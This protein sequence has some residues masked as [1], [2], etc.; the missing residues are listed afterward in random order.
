MPMAAQIRELSNRIQADLEATS[1]YFEHTKALWRLAKQIAGLGQN[2]EIE[3]PESGRALTLADLAVHSQDYVVWICR[4]P[5]SSTSS[6]SLKISSSSCSGFGLLP[7]P[8]AFPT[9]IGKQLTW[10]WSSMPST[11]MPSWGS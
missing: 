1:D 7:I 8:R 2:Y 5:S 3:M 6:R 10:R 11:R 4:N 9:R